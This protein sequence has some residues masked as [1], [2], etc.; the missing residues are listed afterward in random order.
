MCTEAC[1]RISVKDKGGTKVMK[2][3]SSVN[4]IRNE[5]TINEYIV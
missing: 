2:N 1:F 4:F 5:F 3:K